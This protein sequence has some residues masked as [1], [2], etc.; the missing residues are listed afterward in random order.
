MT[1]TPPIADQRFALDAILET[2]EVP[3]D[4]EIVD[5]ILEGAGAVASAIR[6]AGELAKFVGD[7]FLR[8]L[9]LMAVP[10][11]LLVVGLLGLRGVPETMTDRRA[12][13]LALGV[14]RV[15][16]RTFWAYLLPVGLTVY[17]YAVLSLTVFPLLVAGAGFGAVFALVG[18]DLS[19]TT[20]LHIPVDAGVAAAFL[21]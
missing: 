16:R 10:V 19:Q 14:P 5:A 17:T 15:A 3:M 2:I 9:R 12:G 1:Y 20:G 13:R 4:M 6:F 11:V 7:L 21:R 18:G 8:L